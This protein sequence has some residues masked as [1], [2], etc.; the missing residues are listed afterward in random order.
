MQALLGHNFTCCTTYRASASSTILQDESTKKAW[1]LLAQL[2]Q[3]TFA[4]VKQQAE[5]QRIAYFFQVCCW[6]SKQLQISYGSPVMHLKYS[7]VRRLCASAA[8]EDL[9]NQC[10]S[11]VSA[12]CVVKSFFLT[13]FQE[14]Q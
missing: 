1:S 11:C 7:I 2:Q 8:L 14:K 9:C 12:K 4:S 10:H 3:T 13:S 6:H 5:Q